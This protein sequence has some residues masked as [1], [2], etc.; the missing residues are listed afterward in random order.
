MSNQI[1]EGIRMLLARP[2]SELP[3]NQH[4]VNLALLLLAAPRNVLSQ[5]APSKPSDQGVDLL[6]GVKIPMRDGVKLNATVYRPKDQK[7]PLPVIF[8]LTP[9]ISD[10]YHSRAYY[11]AQ[12]GYVFVLVDVRG[13][14]N[15]EGQFE[16]RA[17]EGKDGHDVVEWLAQQP[18]SNGRVVNLRIFGQ[19]LR[20]LWRLVLSRQLPAPALRATVR[21]ELFARALSHLYLEPAN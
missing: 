18:W 8:T 2:R 20:R 10:T 16:P 11:F 21:T 13:R 4:L 3:K 12:N 14:G 5:Q 15:S 19:R 1:G 7:E 9:Y 6:W 17:N